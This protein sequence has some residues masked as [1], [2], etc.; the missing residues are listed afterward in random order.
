MFIFIWISQ[1]LNGF[2]QQNLAVSIH[3]SEAAMLGRITRFVEVAVKNVF[4]DLED[5]MAKHWLPGS[6]VHNMNEAWMST[7]QTLRNSAA[8]RTGAVSISLKLGG[9]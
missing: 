3:K 1:W 8:G 6:R 2:L 7:V 5:L 4:S 9:K